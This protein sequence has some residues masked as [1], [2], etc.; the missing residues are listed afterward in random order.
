M[1]HPCNGIPLSNVLG[2]RIWSQKAMFRKKQNYKDRTQKS[3]CQE[4][5]YNPDYVTWLN[6]KKK[7][8]K[9]KSPN[10]LLF[11]PEAST[12]LQHVKE[13]WIKRFALFKFEN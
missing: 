12:Y 4:L 13:K 2:E 7:K 5:G 9:K 11:S 8:K 10:S 6:L 1:I 3:K